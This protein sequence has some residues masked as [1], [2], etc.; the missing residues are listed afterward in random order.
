MHVSFWGI[1]SWKTQNLHKFFKNQFDIEFYERRSFEYE[2][3]EN[4]YWKWVN[5]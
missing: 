2:I 3:S 1:F 5:F 4:K